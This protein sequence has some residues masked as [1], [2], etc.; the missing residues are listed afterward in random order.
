MRSSNPLLLTALVLA[1]FGCDDST[2]DGNTPPVFRFDAGDAGR[3]IG[4][5]EVDAALPDEGAPPPGDAA[6]G[7]GDGGGPD[8]DAGPT[9]GDQGPGGGDDAGP[10]ADAAPL[11]PV[12]EMLPERPAQQPIDLEARCSERGGDVT[13]YDLR[14]ERCPDF[15]QL[16]TRAPGRAVE[17]E[18]I[19]TAVLRNDFT[20][21]E[22]EG[23]AYG[24]LFVFMGDTAPPAGLVRGARVRLTGQV[25]EFFTLTEFIP[26]RDGVEVLGMAEPPAPIYVE[27]PRRLAD[28]GDLTEPLESVHVEVRNVRVDDTAPD[29]PMDFGMFVVSGGLRVDDVTEF[30]YEPNRRDV[31]RR[32]DGVL[33]YSFEHNKLFPLDDASIDAVDCGGIPDKCEEAECPVEVDARESARLIISE[34][35]SDPRGADDTREFVELYNPGPNPVDVTGWYV[36][37]CAGNRADL[38]GTVPPRDYHVIA[39]SRN[40]DEAG[41]VRADGLMGDLF[42]PNETGSVLVFDADGTLVDQVRYSN[43]APWPERRPGESLELPAPAADNR[44]GA[45]WLAGEDEYGEGGFGTPGR[46][47]Q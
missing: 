32:L 2:A 26:A 43:V 6:P 14:D 17:L 20:A 42:L 1:A 23:G 27:D 7:G 24:S 22:P 3:L 18:L 44:D 31:L 19:V 47:Y 4:D 41:G 34:I 21:A 29:C 15:E 10:E 30:A 36:Q 5:A 39:G 28:E 45:A 37:S 16:P 46:P 38:A 35:Q 8:L 11:D 13:V 40:R 9:P 12:C 33:H 25:I